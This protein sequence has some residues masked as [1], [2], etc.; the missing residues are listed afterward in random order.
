M[1]KTF[2]R[3]QLK[4]SHQLNVITPTLEGFSERG[5]QNRLQWNL[6]VLISPLLRFVN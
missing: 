1:T 4:F 5:V 6:G 3:E 2:F